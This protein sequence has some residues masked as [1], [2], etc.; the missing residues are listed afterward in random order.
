MHTSNPCYDGEVL[1]PAIIGALYT[2]SKLHWSSTWVDDRKL[3]GI[4]LIS[5]GKPKV[6]FFCKEE[7]LEATAKKGVLPGGK[8]VVD[9]G[10]T[11]KNR[12]QSE[13][14][15]AA[16]HW[17]VLVELMSSRWMDKP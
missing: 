4:L 14:V 7:S 10:E 9:I 5:L 11:I 13:S 12:P 8:W 2:N 15:E 1:F 3:T 6:Y 16:I 17:G